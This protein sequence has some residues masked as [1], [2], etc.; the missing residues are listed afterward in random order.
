MA[1]IKCPECGHQVSD[2]APVC[3]NC[4]VEI[5]DK[6]TKC[7]DCG[8]VYFSADAMCPHCYRPTTKKTESAPVVEQTPPSSPI[9]PQPKE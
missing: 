8:E 5:A 2:K 9:P 6:V 4:G 1:I 7:P 3:P